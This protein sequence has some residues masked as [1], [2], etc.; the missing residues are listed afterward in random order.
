MAS[1]DFFKKVA[2]G[3]MAAV[4][5]KSGTHQVTMPDFILMYEK[6]DI[7]SDIRPYLIS[8]DY[9]DYL[10]DQ[11]DELSVE[12]EDVDGKWLRKWYPSQGDSLS[13]SLGDQF[14]GMVALGSFEISEIEYSLPP[15]IITLKALSTGITRAQRTL[16]PKAYENTTLDKIIRT[17]AGRL[18]LSVTGKV[19]DIKIERVSQY[20]ERD[21]EFLARLAKMYGHTFKIVD[22]TLVFM[23]NAELSGQDPIVVMLPEDIKSAR[24]RDMIKAVPDKVVVTGYD[25]KAKQTH[26]VQRKSKPLRPKDK[27]ATTSDTLKIV[28]NKGESEQQLGARADAALQDAQQEQVACTLT[29]FGNAKLVAGQVVQLKEYG[30]FSGKYLVNQCRHSSRRNSGFV[31]TLEMKMIEYIEDVIETPKAEEKTNATNA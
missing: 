27:R 15:S 11:S 25:N 7:T 28:A 22:K 8:Y 31:T 10:G 24:F 26:Q 1:L 6:T 19:K 3:V 23:D 20:Q 13:F 5:A 30:K 9:T 21:V 16:Q 4:Q 18:K 12:F 29:M 14:T 17:I 2:T